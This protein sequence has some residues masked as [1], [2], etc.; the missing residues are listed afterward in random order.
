M[1]LVETFIVLTVAAAL[2]AGCATST[3]PQTAA[4][5]V[6]A[7]GTEAYT[8]TRADGTQGTYCRPSTFSSL[9]WWEWALLPVVLAIGAT[10]L[11]GPGA[12]GVHP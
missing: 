3:L 9:S 10:D 8:Q 7:G 11:T 1:K 4:Q 12:V 6:C 2:L 5:P